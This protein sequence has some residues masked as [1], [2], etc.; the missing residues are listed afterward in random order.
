MN[1][2]L[3]FVQKKFPD[4]CI[5]LAIA[6]LALNISCCNCMSWWMVKESLKVVQAKYPLEVKFVLLLGPGLR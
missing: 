6:Q 5:Y 3:S 2:D 4:K 1:K